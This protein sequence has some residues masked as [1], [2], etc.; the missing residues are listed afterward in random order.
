MNVELTLAAHTNVGKTTLMRTLMRRDIGEV[1][2]RPHVTEAP[3]RHALI[4][5]AAGDVLY[6]CDTPGFGDSHRLLKRLRQ[7]GNPIGWLQTQV[8]D[9]LV[10]RPFFCSQQ[11][12]RAV[13]ESADLVLYLVN[14]AEDPAASAYVEA[15]L[16]ILEWLGKPVV[17]LLNQAGA[18]REAA[19]ARAEEERWQARLAAR[20]PAG[21]VL[22]LDAFS[23]CWVQEDR[24]LEVASA[25]LP[26]G[27]RASFQALRAAWRERNLEV[28]ASSMRV[29][30]GMLAATAVDREPI[31]QGGLAGA[32]AGVRRLAARGAEPRLDPAERAALE[33]SARRLAERE[34]AAADELIALHGLAGSARERVVAG[35]EA[36]VDVARPVNVAGTGALGGLVS[37]ALGGLAADLAAG[38]LTLGAGTIAGAVL[39]VLGAGGAAHAYNA[40]MGLDEGRL[41]WKPA[42]LTERLSAALLLYLAVAHYGRGRGAWIEEAAPAHWARHIAEAMATRR[43]QI[44]ELWA[45]AAGEG[46]SQLA[47]AIE[48]Q[49]DGLARGVLER[50]YPEARAAL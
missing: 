49:L 10:D 40:A 9:R 29:L 1:A 14:A 13:R 32:L 28:F 44:D 22:T 19:A 26:E 3:E 25:L 24:L 20:V 45:F 50:L 43:A 47:P 15:E 38:G 48:A 16:Q 6:L 46:V 2:D 5:T 8:W 27:K 30:A 39:G 37:G 36:A 41:G 31:A 11:A 21:R 4:E 34:R 23:R 7:S 17:L 18:P 35:L 33:A 42:L 12:V